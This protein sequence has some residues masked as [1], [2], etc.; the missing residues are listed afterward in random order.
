MRKILMLDVDGVLNS[1]AWH[2]GRVLKDYEDYDS[3]EDWD[4]HSGMDPSAVARLNTIV[5]QTNCEIVISSTWRYLGVK[6][7]GFEHIARMLVIQGFKYPDKIIGATPDLS[8]TR[9]NGALIFVGVPRGEEIW[10]WLV[11]NVPETYTLVILDDEE[12]MAHLKDAL[13]QT[14]YLVGLSDNHVLKIVKRFNE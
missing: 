5:E 12:D 2:K 1:H 9:V 13:V 4:A 10:K 6:E 3:Q 11:E 7:P 14:D 8:T